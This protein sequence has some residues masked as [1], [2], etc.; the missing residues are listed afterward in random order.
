MLTSRLDAYISR[1]GDFCANNNDDRLLYRL[2]MRAGRLPHRMGFE[3][4][5]P[6]KVMIGLIYGMT[7]LPTTY[8]LRTS[9]AGDQ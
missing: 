1:Y 8:L 2:R 4:R 6:E 3:I 9:R 5:K 7:G